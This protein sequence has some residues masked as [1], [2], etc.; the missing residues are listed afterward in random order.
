MMM[1]SYLNV[2]TG[3]FQLHHTPGLVTRQQLHHVQLWRLW[4]PLLWVLW[5]HCTT[6]VLWGT[7]C[8]CV[9]VSSCDRCVFSGDV[10]NGC[11][12]I[13]NR[14]ECKDINWA[15]YT[16]VLGYHVFGKHTFTPVPE[17]RAVCF[18]I[19]YFWQTI[20]N[21]FVCSYFIV[22]VCVCVCVCVRCVA[23]GFR[24]HRHQRSH[25]ISQQEGDRSSRRLL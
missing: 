25:Q 3:T 5:L 7:L 19:W 8:T 9:P 18:H 4:D 23:G 6:V 24:R 21:A 22:C 16:C 11:K 2:S 10:P 17:S 1:L 20:S 12:L 14:S 13:R 15:T